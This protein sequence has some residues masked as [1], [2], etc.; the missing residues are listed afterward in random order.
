MM[1]FERERTGGNWK[2]EEGKRRKKKEQGRR[3]KRKEKVGWWL[4][5]LAGHSQSDR[6]F[7]RATVMGLGLDPKRV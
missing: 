6:G 3:K 2:E 4:A 5:G 7:D 1:E